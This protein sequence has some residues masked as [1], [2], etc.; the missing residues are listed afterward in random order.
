LS[1]STGVLRMD[2]SQLDAS[3]PYRLIVEDA[4]TRHIEYF[5]NPHDALERWAEFDAA[6]RS[7]TSPSSPALTIP[8]RIH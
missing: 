3:G 1:S 5:A 4:T 8:V 2:L 7:D 6:M